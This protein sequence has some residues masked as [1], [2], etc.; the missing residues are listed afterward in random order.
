MQMR[1]YAAMLGW[2]RSAVLI[3]VCNIFCF[4]LLMYN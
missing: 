4:S 2:D 1:T 3:R